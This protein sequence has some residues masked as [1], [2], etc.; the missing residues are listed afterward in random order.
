M[1]GSEYR[2]V[3]VWSAARIPLLAD[4]GAIAKGK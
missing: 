1:A 3:T 2:S 4:R